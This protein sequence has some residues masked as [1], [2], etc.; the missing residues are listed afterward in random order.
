MRNRYVHLLLPAL[1]VSIT[2]SASRAQAGRTEAAAVAATVARFHQALSAGDSTAAL[3]ILAED[4]VILESG[5]AE[6][7]DEYRAHHLPGDIAFARA[8]RP[9]L[10]RVRVTLGGDV[11]WAASTSTTAGEFEGRP[12]DA[13]TAELVVLSRTPGGWRI[14]A[15][16]WSSRP[17]RP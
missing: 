4:A 3:A 7:K 10:G 15:I 5:G 8:V 14:R 16:H 6:T 9:A 17:R 1:L 13:A 2:P 11:A 12:V